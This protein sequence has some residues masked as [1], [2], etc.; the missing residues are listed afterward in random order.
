MKECFIFHFIFLT[1]YL[2]F[3]SENKAILWSIFYVHFYFLNYFIWTFLFFTG[4]QILSLFLRRLRDRTII[5][6]V[7]CVTSSL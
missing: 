4:Y 3:I 1:D 6:N 2:F 7:Q 5:I